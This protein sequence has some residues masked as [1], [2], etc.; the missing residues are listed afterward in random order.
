M[1]PLSWLN[2]AEAWRTFCAKRL[3]TPQSQASAGNIDLIANGTIH[4]QIRGLL[5]LPLPDLNQAIA[6]LRHAGGVDGLRRAPEV[7]V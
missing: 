3:E 6:G 4:G 7:H 2:K 5:Y 1:P